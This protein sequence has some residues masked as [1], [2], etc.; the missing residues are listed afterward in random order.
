[1]SEI[2][3]NINNI[4]VRTWRWLGVNEADFKG[5]IP[6]L[7]EYNRIALVSTT[8]NGVRLIDIKGKDGTVKLFENKAVSG[9][10]EELTE[11]ALKHYNTGY[12]IEI[13]RGRNI[14]EPVFIQYHMDEENPHVIDNN[15]IIAEE[16]SSSTIVMKYSSDENLDAFHN[17]VTKIYAKKGAVVNLVKVQLMEDEAVHFDGIASI[18]E[19]GAE[20]NFVLIELGAK[21][22]ITSCKNDLLDRGARSNIHSIYL[23][24]KDRQIDINYV[25]NH[26]GKECESIIETKGVLMDKSSKI[27]RGTLDFRKGASG[28]KGKE[29]EYA[30]LLSS[31]VRNRSVPLLL[32]G[33]DNVEGQHAASSGKIDEN[34]LF[35][36]MSRGFSELD[37]KKL[38]VEAAFNPITERVPLIELKEEISEYIR[39]RL[40]NV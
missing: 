7:K 6:Q 19:E 11:L 9:V 39:R 10:S 40:V 27:F 21:N 14:E 25:M 30:V 36:L 2:L 18:A 20:I 4:P 24:D 22:S 26:L 8:E 1:M 33:E 13:E 12:L 17:G 38:I 28:S 29:E 5:S 31:N 3:K 37:A 32:C 23:G 16:N 15:M 34:K 35:Y